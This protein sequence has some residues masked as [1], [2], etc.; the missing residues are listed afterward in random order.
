MKKFNVLYD[1]TVVCNI[2]DRNSLRSGI[3]FVAY[4]VLLELLKSPEFNVYLYADNL[5]KLQRVIDEY[6]E[7][8]DCKIYQFTIWQKWVSFF[9]NLKE[10]NKKR[11]GSIFL[12]GIYGLLASILKKCYMLTMNKVN[13]AGIDV[14]FSPMKAAPKFISNNKRIKCFTILHDAIPMVADS[15]INSQTHKWYGKL[16]KSINER[17]F[18][19][20]NSEYTKRDFLKYIPNIVDDRIS[21]IPLSTGK[22]YSKVTSLAEINSVKNKYNIPLE[23]KYIFSLCSLNPRK[24][25]I[26]AIRNFLK[27]V[28]RNKLDDFVF[29]LGGAFFDGFIE[30]FNENLESYGSLKDRVIHVGYV[31]DED[32]S[33]LYSGA[34]MFLYPSLYEGFGMPILEAMQCGLPVICSNCTSMPEVVGDCG[35]QIDPRADEEMVLAMEKMYFDGEF[36]SICIQKGLERAKL[37][38][39]QK[40]GDIIIKKLCSECATKEHYDCARS[41]EKNCV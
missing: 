10:E 38:T 20:A 24:N 18:Y 17:S 13:L 33:A 23:Q 16:V 7:F 15:D 41:V 40:C 9:K 11:K 8:S 25:L 36:R 4:N 5:F 31:D 21:V 26:F 6:P 30:V 27:F 14:Y 19:F 3:F 2:L 29:V 34:E 28:S 35:I 39:W 12:R 22:S 32:L 37:F 1:A